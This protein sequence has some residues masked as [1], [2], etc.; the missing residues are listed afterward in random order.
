MILLFGW[1]EPRTL[2]NTDTKQQEDSLP[3]HI[4]YISDPFH[5][6]DDN[7]NKQ[8]KFFVECESNYD[9]FLINIF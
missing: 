6:S 7:H 4:T 8:G 3:I 1:I 2:T 9:K 5:S